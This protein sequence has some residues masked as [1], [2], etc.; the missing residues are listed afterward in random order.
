MTSFTTALALTDQLVGALNDAGLVVASV[1]VAR[2]REISIQIDA[3]RTDAQLNHLAVTVLGGADVRYPYPG[4]E[5]GSNAYSRCNVG[6]FVVDLYC[7]KTAQVS[8]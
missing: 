4:C 8:A 5:E 6:L 7:A 1:Q 2:D 3:T